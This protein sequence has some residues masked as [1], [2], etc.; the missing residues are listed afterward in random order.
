MTTAIDGWIRQSQEKILSGAGVTLQD[1]DALRDLQ[2]GEQQHL[3]YIW[4]EQDRIDAGAH[5]VELLRPLRQRVPL[6]SQKR[7]SVCQRGLPAM[8]GMGW[9]VVSFPGVEYPLENAHKPTRIRVYLRALFPARRG[10]G[11]YAARPAPINGGAMEANWKELKREFFDTGYVV[12][13]GWIEP[14][15]VERT[16][17]DAHQSGGIDIFECESVGDLL[18]HRPRSSSSSPSCWRRR[19][20]PSAP[21]A[22]GTTSRKAAKATAAAGTWT[23]PIWPTGRLTE[24][25]C[26]Y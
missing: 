4:A 6:R 17:Q 10:V 18:C 3:L 13:D 21:S 5:R 12:L 25:L 9:R 7:M 22:S 11:F 14:E 23:T 24:I 26:M 8:A 1:L 16:N 19:R 2:S 20:W 15:L